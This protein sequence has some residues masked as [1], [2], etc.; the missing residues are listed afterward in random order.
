MQ[1]AKAKFLFK[2]ELKSA[3]EGFGP[4]SQETE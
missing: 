4:H 3:N 1:R 2:N